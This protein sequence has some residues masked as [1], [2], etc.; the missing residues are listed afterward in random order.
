MLQGKLISEVHG[1]PGSSINSFQVGAN[2]D[3]DVFAGPEPSISFNG[4]TATLVYRPKSNTQ[5]YDA[6]NHYPQKACVFVA[7]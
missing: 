3:D 6:Q 5:S 2:S 7:K 4:G 1:S